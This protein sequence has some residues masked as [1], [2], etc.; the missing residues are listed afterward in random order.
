MR[1]DL[2]KDPDLYPDLHCGKMMPGGRGGYLLLG[3]SLDDDD[4]DDDVLTHKVAKRLSLLLQAPWPKQWP[5][6]SAFLFIGWFCPS[7][8]GAGLV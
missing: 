2:A 1:K 6:S 7:S 5:R 8:H 4:D 3:L